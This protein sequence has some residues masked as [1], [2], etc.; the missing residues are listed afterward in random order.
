VKNLIFTYETE[1]FF[2]LL[3]TCYLEPTLELIS[4][5]QNKV[6]LKKTE[7][8]VSETKE[9]IMLGFNLSEG[10]GLN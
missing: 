6:P 3:N 5:I 1:D 2:E 10:L 4:E 9:R 8:S 7:K